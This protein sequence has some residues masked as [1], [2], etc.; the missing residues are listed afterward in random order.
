[1]RFDRNNEGAK[2]LHKT[3][4]LEPRGR[5]AQESKKLLDSIK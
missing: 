4:E 5:L 1:M 2:E 3:I